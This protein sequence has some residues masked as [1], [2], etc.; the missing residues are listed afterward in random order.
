MVILSHG[1]LKGAFL[2]FKRF[3]KCNPLFPGGVDLPPTKDFL[4]E[5]KT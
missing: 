5:K 4:K 1:V 2:A 3:L